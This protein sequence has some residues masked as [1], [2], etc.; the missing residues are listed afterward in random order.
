MKSIEIYVSKIIHRDTIVTLAKKSGINRKE[1]EKKGLDPTQR[2]G[3]K[4]I[5]IARAYRG[6]SLGKPPTKEQIEE[7][8][9]LGISLESKKRTS[10][11]IAEALISSLTDMEMADIEDSAL[12]DL[13]KKRKKEIDICETK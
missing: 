11:E 3:V 12:K 9:K 8:K 7:L 1:L 6:N 2:I 13:V 10:K 5:E 4:K